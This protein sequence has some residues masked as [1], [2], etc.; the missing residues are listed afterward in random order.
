MKNLKADS[1]A[2]R[3]LQQEP[4]YILYILQNVYP[5]MLEHICAFLFMY[6]RLVASFK[7]RRD[8]FPPSKVLKL[9]RFPENPEPNWGPKARA[10]RK[11]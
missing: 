11:Y 5:I 10:K 4:K 7:I 1:P 9:A 6:F 8:A 3:I 2:A